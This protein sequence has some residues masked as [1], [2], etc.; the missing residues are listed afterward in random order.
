MFA[1][2]LNR[3]NLTTKE[4]LIKSNSVI[5]SEIELPA[6]GQFRKLRNLPRILSKGTAEPEIPAHRIL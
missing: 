4:A 2:K 5:P 3:A 1:R 6:F